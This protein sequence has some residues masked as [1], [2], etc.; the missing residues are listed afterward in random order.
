MAMMTVEMD[1]MNLQSTASQRVGH[2]SV[3]CS[4]A[5]METAFLVS[6]SVMVITIASTTLTKMRDISAVCNLF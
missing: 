3:I 5:I 2:A 1:L 6:T 4:H